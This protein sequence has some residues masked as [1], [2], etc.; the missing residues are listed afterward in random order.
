MTEH[1]EFSDGSELEEL[2]ELHRQ[3]RMPAD[4]RRRL[5]WRWRNPNARADGIDG[6]DAP[7][8]FAGQSPHSEGARLDAAVPPAAVPPAALLD[9]VVPD[10]ARARP[11]RLRPVAYAFAASALMAVAALIAVGGL[12]PRSGVERELVTI[13]PEAPRAPNERARPSGNPSQAEM[14]VVGW[15]IPKSLR[16][17]PSTTDPYLP[18]R[19]GFQLSPLTS[20]SNAVLRVEYAHCGL[21]DAMV[22][23][24]GCVKITADGYLDDDGHV[25]ASRVLAE[26]VHCQP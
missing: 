22:A 20:A 16:R 13:D 17:I 2:R 8:G 3:D 18:C 9:A 25:E 12:G 19:Y 21:P 5:L 23:G 11:R 6:G 24:A 4:V 1:D 15:L 26:E 10:A 7:L 14:R